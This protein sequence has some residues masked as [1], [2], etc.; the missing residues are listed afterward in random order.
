MARLFYDNAGKMAVIRGMGLPAVVSIAGAGGVNFGGNGVIV[1]QIGLGQSANVQ[2]Q[3]SLRQSIYVYS[4]GDAMGSLQIGGM[5]YMGQRCDG[6]GGGQQV[7]GI[8]DILRFYS[9]NRI[10]VTGK[11]VTVAIGRTALSG[12]L[13]GVQAGNSDSENRLFNWSMSLAA[14]PDFAGLGGG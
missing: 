4:F 5:A 10:S 13:M 6:G 12:F 9:T 11:H 3:P 8:A 7:D 1:T 14:L 2:I